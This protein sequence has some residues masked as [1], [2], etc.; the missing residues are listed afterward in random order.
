MS[1]VR[2]GEKAFEAERRLGFNPDAVPGSLRMMS[3]YEKRARVEAW[4]AS[5]Y[6]WKPES[7]MGPYP[8]W[9]GVKVLGEGGY[10]TAGRWELVHGP[11]PD[12]DEDRLPFK[13]CVVKQQ[14]GYSMQSESSIH[15]LFRHV[16]SQHLV[17][18]YRRMYQDQGLGTVRADR[19]GPVYRMYLEDCE[20]GDLDLLIKERFQ[21]RYGICKNLH[22][23]TNLPEH[24]LRNMRYGMCFIAWLAL[25]TLCITDMK[26]LIGSDGIEMRSFIS[27]S[28]V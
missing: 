21:Q 3:A 13:S 18:M 27:I 23:Y 4:L 1:L 12:D 26:S 8:A 20:G 24:T 10:G 7:R 28:K 25:S 16:P 15:E 22:L 11:L 17:K 9:R 14:S 6:L 2:P 19:K 5:E